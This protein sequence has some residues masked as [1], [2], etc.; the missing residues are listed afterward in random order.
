MKQRRSYLIDKSKVH[1]WNREREEHTGPDGLGLSS[2]TC[3]LPCCAKTEEFG[4]KNCEELLLSNFIGE[5]NGLGAAWGELWMNSLPNVDNCCVTPNSPDSSTEIITQMT[6]EID[7]I[8][9]CLF[10]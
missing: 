1:T 7:N 9:Q 4:E 8:I 5:A 3:G 2:A 6:S 10:L